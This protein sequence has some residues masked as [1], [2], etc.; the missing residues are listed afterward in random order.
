MKYTAVMLELHRWTDDKTVR[1]VLDRDAGER[2]GGWFSVCPYLSYDQKA[3]M[4]KATA[5]EYA[6]RMSF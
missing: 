4:T 3:S 2:V 6:R 5:V 1:R